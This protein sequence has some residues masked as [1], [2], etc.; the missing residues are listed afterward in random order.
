MKRL[1]VAL[2]AFILLPLV[3]FSE[4]PLTRVEDFESDSARDV[5]SKFKER[6]AFLEA[7][8]D[9]QL[10]SADK[11]LRTGLKEALASSVAAGELKEVERISKFLQQDPGD[12][13][14]K[15]VQTDVAVLRRRVAELERKLALATATDPI[16]GK[17]RYHNNNICDYTADG[18]VTLNG[19]AIGL[20]RRTTGRQ[21]VVAFVR[22]FA[23]GVSDDMVLSA[24]GKTIAASGAK[25]QKFQIVR[26]P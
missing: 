21:Y 24:D 9:E 14:K 19:K 26:L 11:D 16:V 22:A 2:S 25:G 18:W 13:G 5:V 4:S 1:V 15:P 20:W 12:Q 6:I 17:W 10:A 7:R 3:A 23:K 8:M